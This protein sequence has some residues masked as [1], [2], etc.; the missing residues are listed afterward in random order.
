MALGTIWVQNFNLVK[1][2]LHEMMLENI[3]HISI[4][5]SIV[6]IF[7]WHMDIKQAWK[8]VTVLPRL[9]SRWDLQRRS[10]KRKMKRLRGNK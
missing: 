6:S 10:V 7:Q 1:F 5:G 4:N 9:Y 3:D 2:I 8:P